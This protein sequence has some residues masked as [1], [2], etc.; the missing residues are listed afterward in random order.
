M[1]CF[2]NSS[3][4]FI[5]HVQF[6]IIEMIKW[7]KR[8]FALAFRFHF[9]FYCSWYLSFTYIYKKNRSEA[10]EDLL[11]TARKRKDLFWETRANTWKKIIYCS[12]NTTLKRKFR[13]LSTLYRCNGINSNSSFPR[14][15][16]K[17]VN[18]FCRVQFDSY[19]MLFQFTALAGKSPVNSNKVVL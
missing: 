4:L 16:L 9:H 1:W 5:H 7:T 2:N 3:C 13:F 14:D 17:I 11:I 19:F 10:E 12:T 8:D 18:I 15:L 6:S